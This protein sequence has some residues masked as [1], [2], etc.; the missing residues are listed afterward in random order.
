[1]ATTKREGP[2][3]HDLGYNDVSK[4]HLRVQTV[5]YC[6]TIKKKQAYNY[7]MISDC[8]NQMCAKIKDNDIVT[9]DEYLGVANYALVNYR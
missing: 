6:G 1:M 7:L 8:V 3:D 5:Q 4:H 9:R 2:P